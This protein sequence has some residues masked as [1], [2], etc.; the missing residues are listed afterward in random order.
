[1]FKY[2]QADEQSFEARI[3]PRA[4]AYGE[5]LWSNALTADGAADGSWLGAEHRMVTNRLRMV[6]RGVRADRLQPEFCS[7]YQGK[8]YGW[9]DFPQE[10]PEDDNKS[11]GY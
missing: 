10:K 11:K 4:A 2:F 6:A 7:A 1:M 8:C 3:W 9:G 5:R